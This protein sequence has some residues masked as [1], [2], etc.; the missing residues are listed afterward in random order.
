[1]EHVATTGRS[2]RTRLLAAVVG[3][4]LLT[5]LAVSTLAATT[6]GHADQGSQ[7]VI[8]GTRWRYL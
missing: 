1:M 2:A 7:A 3:A 4:I 6:V 8:D 5:S